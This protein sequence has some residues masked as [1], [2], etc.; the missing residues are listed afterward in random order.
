MRIG[1]KTVSPTSTFRSIA[2]R[3]WYGGIIAGIRLLLVNVCR[4]LATQ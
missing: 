1:V 4:I 3:Q 2:P